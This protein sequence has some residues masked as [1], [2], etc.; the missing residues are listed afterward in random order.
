MNSK[1]PLFFIIGSVTLMFLGRTP[2]EEWMSYVNVHVKTFRTPGWRTKLNYNMY[3]FLAWY[4][5]KKRSV[6]YL[7]M[8]EH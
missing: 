5:P 2:I 4:A 6:F 7:Q 3:C 1:L 8:M